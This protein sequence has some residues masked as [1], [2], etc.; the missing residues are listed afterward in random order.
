MCADAALIK[1]TANKSRCSAS[2]PSHFPLTLTQTHTLL[3]DA[4]AV[5]LIGISFRSCRS[6]HFCATCEKEGVMRQ[7]LQQQPAF[8]PSD[9]AALLASC[10][11]RSR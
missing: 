10:P 5:Q 4:H 2:F 6:L 8:T 11:Q 9:Q 1:S 3:P 7:E